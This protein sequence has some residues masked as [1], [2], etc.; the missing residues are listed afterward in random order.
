MYYIWV[1]VLTMQYC[2]FCTGIRLFLGLGLRS[3]EFR[4]NTCE[5]MPP[6]ELFMF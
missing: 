2:T 5:V 6:E 3:W 4:E 1:N